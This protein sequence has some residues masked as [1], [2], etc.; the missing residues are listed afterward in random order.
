MDIIRDE[1]NETVPDRVMIESEDAQ[2]ISATIAEEGVII[3]RDDLSSLTVTTADGKEEIHT[4]ANSIMIV[5]GKEG[6][7]DFYE[8]VNGDG[9][10]QFVKSNKN[11]FQRAWLWLKSIREFIADKL[12]KR[13]DIKKDK[14][15]KKEQ[16]EQKEQPPAAVDD[17]S[18]DQTGI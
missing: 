13:D 16:K 10:Y 17:E 11:L 1:A 2:V 5:G 7:V 14:K 8:D 18:E 9:T 3:D 15:D 4:A 6:R 12:F